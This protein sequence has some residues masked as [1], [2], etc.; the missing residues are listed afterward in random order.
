MECLQI[1]YY[2]NLKKEKSCDVSIINNPPMGKTRPGWK[3]N[4]NKVSSE[5]IWSLKFP[6]FAKKIDFPN[7]IE[8]IK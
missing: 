3:E 6:L 8:M 5:Q 7:K 1:K 4:F 2:V